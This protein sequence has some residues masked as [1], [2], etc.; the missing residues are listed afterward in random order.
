LAFIISFQLL[1]QPHIG[2]QVEITGETALRYF[3]GKSFMKS[4]LIGTLKPGDKKVILEVKPWK[5]NDGSKAYI[6]RVGRLVNGEEVSDGEI[7]YRDDSKTVKLIPATQTPKQ[8]AKIP[9]EEAKY[10]EALS[11]INLYNELGQ[12]ASA[13]QLAKGERLKLINDPKYYPQN[14]NSPWMRVEFPSSGEEYYIRKESF[15]K[16]IILGVKQQIDDFKK[17][18]VD[19]PNT[20]PVGEQVAPIVAAVTMVP[21]FKPKDL[22]SSKNLLSVIRLTEGCFLR[23]YICPAGYRTIG[24]GHRCD[25]ECPAIITKEKMDQLLRDDVLKFEKLVREE[26][27]NVTLT[28]GQFDALVSMAFNMGNKFSPRKNCTF[29]RLIDL[30]L[31]PG[32]NPTDG[33]LLA[34]A[35]EITRFQY[36]N[37]D[38]V[39]GLQRRRVIESMLFIKN[40]L[41]PVLEG[42]TGYPPNI[43]KVLR[44]L[45]EKM[46]S[47]IPEKYQVEYLGD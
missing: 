34:I 2:D 14:T 6:L 8:K 46:Q 21:R 37:S 40:A 4:E 26:F 20:C 22:T 12:P 10:I 42:A 38:P 41:T 17:I 33:Q 27:K 30:A 28:Q 3:N 5:N 44:P 32:K 7:F 11:E 36:S 15:P 25:D 39:L 43:D 19:A 9:I 18:G 35:G 16:L 1:A 13:A 29:A 47:T 45:Y 23:P 24:C 31:A